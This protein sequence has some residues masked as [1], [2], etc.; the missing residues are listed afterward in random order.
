MVSGICFTNES[1]LD[2]KLF[3]HFL[4]L[5]KIITVRNHFRISSKLDVVYDAKHIYANSVYSVSFYIILEK[6]FGLLIMLKFCET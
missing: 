3:E 4:Y 5:N 2:A 6:K 1:E